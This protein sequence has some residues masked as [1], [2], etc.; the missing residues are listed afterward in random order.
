M[1]I[2]CSQVRAN[3]IGKYLLFCVSDVYL[4]SDSQ[5]CCGFCCAEQSL[6]L[7]QIELDISSVGWSTYTYKSVNCVNVYGTTVKVASDSASD[8]A[9]HSTVFNHSKVEFQKL[10]FC[11]FSM[12]FSV[13]IS[14]KMSIATYLSIAG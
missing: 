1:V 2:L 6:M 7:N 12:Y 11:L 3:E 9:S 8:W 14:N 13:E 5:I 10:Y 4:S